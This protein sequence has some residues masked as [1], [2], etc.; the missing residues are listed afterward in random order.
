[1]NLDDLRHEI[2]K[3]DDNIIYFICKRLQ[4]I[5]K[6]AIWKTKNN[7]SVIDKSRE[8]EIINRILKKADKYQIDQKLIHKLFKLLIYESKEIQKRKI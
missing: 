4:L 5:K 6:I 7:L 1:M 2:D 3:I 8:H